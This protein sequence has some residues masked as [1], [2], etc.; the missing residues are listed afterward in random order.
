MAKSTVTSNAKAFVA[1][2]D[3]G[4]ID[5]H[6]QIMNQLTVNLD[7][8]RTRSADQ[9]IIARKFSKPNAPPSKQIAFLTRKQPVDRKRLTERTGLLK[10][11]LL[12]KGEWKVPKTR[13]IA[14]FKPIRKGLNFSVRPQ[15]KQ[16]E[17]SYKATLRFTNDPEWRFRANHEEFGDR[18][19]RR[20]PFIRPSIDIE[21]RL[22]PKA[23]SKTIKKIE[24]SMTR[25]LKAVK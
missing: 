15:L 19:G 10:R 17:V 3:K 13:H 2:L 16:K 25:R 6:I 22:I 21:S 8:I 5:Y 12:S 7:S 14:K 18:L 1:A 20:R 9:F 23:L 11:I 4:N 24:R